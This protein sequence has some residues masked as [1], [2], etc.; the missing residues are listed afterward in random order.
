MSRYN[1]S[2]PSFVTQLEVGLTRNK[3]TYNSKRGQDLDKEASWL[4]GISAFVLLF[5]R[6]GGGKDQLVV[7]RPVAIRACRCKGRWNVFLRHHHPPLTGLETWDKNPPEE[8]IRSGAQNFLGIWNIQ[9]K[10]ST[11]ESLLPMVNAVYV[12]AVYSVY[13]MSLLKWNSQTWWLLRGSPR[14]PPPPPPQVGEHCDGGTQKS[15]G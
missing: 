10:V 8:S 3:S 11:Q 6:F 5:R 12:H 9:P 13:D 4:I 7:G 15:G 1:P 2:K 14:S